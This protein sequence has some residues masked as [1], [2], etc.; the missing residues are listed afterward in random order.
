MDKKKLAQ[1][2]AIICIASVVLML[3][4]M[5]VTRWDLFWVIPIIGVLVCMVLSF[6]LGTKDE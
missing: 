5:N 4:V 3:V 2:W 1:L 6:V